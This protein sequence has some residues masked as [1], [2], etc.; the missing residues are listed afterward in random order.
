MTFASSQAVDPCAKVRRVIRRRNALPRFQIFAALGLGWGA[1]GRQNRDS[2]KGAAE[3]DPES[4]RRARKDSQT[5]RRFFAKRMQIGK[6]VST[7]RRGIGDA[8]ESF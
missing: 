4:A 2:T 5:G 7:W 3:S 6:I 8:G 1:A